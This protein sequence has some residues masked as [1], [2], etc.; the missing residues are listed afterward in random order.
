MIKARAVLFLNSGLPVKF[1]PDK[2]DF[3][4]GVD[5]GTKLITRLGLKPDVIIGDLDSLPHPPKNIPVLKYPV[6]KDKTDSELALDYAL[7][8]GF[9]EILIV[10]FFGNRLDHMISN[11]FLAATSRVKVS[12]IT[13]NQKLFFIHEPSRLGLVGKPGQLVSLI[14]LK[15]N[16]V[17]TTIGLKWRLQGETLKVGSSQGVSNEMI[18]KKAT[19]KVSKGVLL[20][21]HTLS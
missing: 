7:R 1:N 4:I 6:D 2:T 15:G 5:G 20:V 14:P 12:I 21:V 16:C 3:L 10:G 13:Q 18:G 17:V 8:K 19:I 11:L 9:K